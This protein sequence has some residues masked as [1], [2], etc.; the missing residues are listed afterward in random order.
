MTKKTAPK[1][2]KPTQLDRIEKMI[3]AMF[4]ADEAN[5][6]TLGDFWSR[7][8][9]IIDE[10]SAKL[11]RIEALLSPK[12]I[13]VDE[14][15]VPKVGDWAVINTPHGRSKPFRIIHIES[16]S[17]LT[18]YHLGE[19]M[20]GGRWLLE[21]IRPASKEE[22]EAHTKAE[23]QRKREQE[24]AE[25]VAQDRKEAIEQL[26]AIKTKLVN[27]RDYKGAKLVRDA[28]RYLLG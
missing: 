21:S 11:E 2:R 22:I 28:E 14:K 19:K 12:P 27:A 10:H 25:K 4:H 3:S 1:K 13:E 16:N 8:G 7:M 6:K 18:Y 24:S 23:E 9:G 5:A 20:I 26:V 17:G 15:W